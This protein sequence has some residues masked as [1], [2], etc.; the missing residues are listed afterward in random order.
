MMSGGGPMVSATRHK[1][2]RL[3][4]KALVRRRSKA[5][6]DRLGNDVWT[7]TEH[8]VDCFWYS[9]MPGEPTIVRHPREEATVRIVTLP[10][11]LRPD[12][13]I[14]LPGQ[15]GRPYEVIGDSEDYNH[16]PFWFQPGVVVYNLKRTEG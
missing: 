15:E 6:R 9:T 7:T 16:G 4:Y 5:G 14:E 10:G 3:P 13:Q 11:A 1:K 8:Q 2:L 12:D